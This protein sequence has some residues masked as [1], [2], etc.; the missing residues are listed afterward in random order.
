MNARQPFGLRTQPIGQDGGASPRFTVLELLVVVGIVAVILTML[1]SGVRRVRDMAAETACKSNLRIVTMALLAYRS[2]HLAF[3]H[4]NL[5]EALALHGATGKSLLCPE[6]NR[7]YEQFYIPHQAPM[8]HRDYLIGCPHHGK[9]RI[10]FYQTG[11]GVSER[12]AN[13]HW[14]GNPVLPG[15]TV[16]GGTIVFDD[17]STIRLA[18]GTRA[19][20]VTSFWG[21]DRR[22]HSIV[23][24]PRQTSSGILNVDVSGQSRFEVVTPAAVVGALGT[25]FRITITAGGNRFQTKIEVAAGDV[26]A[27][28]QTGQSRLL[29][30]GETFTVEAPAGVALIDFVPQSD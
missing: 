10:N 6:T 21:D 7:H 3:P 12:A 1:L 24:V 13:I 25:R 18:S 5:A 26:R 4:G 19:L 20:I 2:D 30:A 15:D 28:A 29:R 11:A 27:L 9:R 23:R 8:Y 14:N 17:G 22:L 16:T